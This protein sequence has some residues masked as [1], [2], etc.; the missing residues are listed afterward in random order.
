MKERKWDDRDVNVKVVK[1][2]PP[3]AI[4]VDNLLREPEKDLM[5]EIA[6]EREK[7]RTERGRRNCT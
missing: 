3:K 5:R 6:Q 4:L 1:K 2:A 7:E